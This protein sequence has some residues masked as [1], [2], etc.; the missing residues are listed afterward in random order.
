MDL[1]KSITKITKFIG[2]P[3]HSIK[4][5]KKIDSRQYMELDKDG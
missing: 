4:K 3:A 1:F 2:I 5:V